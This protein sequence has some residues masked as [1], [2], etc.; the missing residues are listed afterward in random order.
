M[1]RTFIALA[2]AALTTASVW[3]VP[4]RRITKTIEQP[5]GT[6][7]EVTL[8]GDEW[9]HSY[10][11]SDNLAVWINDEGYAVYVTT[12]GP[13]TILAH[14][15]AD[16]S[17]DEQTAIAANSAS[18]N[19]AAVRAEAPKY[20]A[21]MAELREEALAR[22]E[23][24]GQDVSPYRVSSTT[25]ED[26][27][28]RVSLEQGASQVPHKGTAKVPIILVNFSNVSFKNSSTAN[29]TFT[30]F[31]MGEDN[32]SCHK[33]FSDASNGLYDPQFDI[34]GPFTVANNRKY[35]GGSS[36]NGNDE[37]PQYLVRDALQLADPTTDF[38]EY[39]NDGDGIVDVVIVLYA[40]V[41]QAS[42]GVAEAVWPCQW[43]LSSGGVGKYNTNDGVK[44]DKFA[45][46]NELNGANQS[47]I[48]GPGT[49]CHEFSHCLGLPDFYETTY[50]YGYMG[51]DVW[52]LMDYGC[53]N[54]DG[55]TP[56]GYTAYEKAFM[57]WITLLEGQPNTKYNLPVLNKEGE[58]N[59]DAVIL[60]NSKDK[61]EY[62]IFEN[63]DKQGWDKYMD[64][65]GMLITHVTYSSSA[66]SNNSVNNYSLQRM[67]IVP[68]DNKFDTY[69][70]SGD[71]W[72]KSYAYE[73]TNTSVP[74][75]TTNTGSFLNREVTEISR[76]SSTGNVTFWVDRAPVS[77]V[78]PPVIN[79][80]EYAP[81]LAEE[82]GAFT[83]KWG[84]TEIEGCDVSYILQVWEKTDGMTMP[85]VW[86]DFTKDT[87]V[88]WNQDGAVDKKKNYV[89]LGNTSGTTGVLTSPCTVAAEDGCI[90]VVAYAKR[91]GTDSGAEIKLSLV[92]ST[93]ATG[94]F[95]TV[96]LGNLKQY[97]KAVLKGE[98]GKVYSVRIENT[99][100]ARI[101]A[102]NV[103]AFEGD[104]SDFTD[105]EFQ[106]ALNAAYNAEAAPA[107]VEVSTSPAGR[108]TVKGIRETSY[109]VTGLEN[110]NGTYCYRV[111]AVP[112][113]DTIGL[114]SFWSNTM[115]VTLHE[116]NA[117]IV[118]VETSP[119]TSGFTVE[120]GNILATPGARLYTMSGLEVRATAAGRFSV[121]PGAYILITPGF[122]PSKVIVK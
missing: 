79:E 55:Y 76:D 23:A 66:W 83:A 48:D 91:F 54:D 58:Q 93:G 112:D 88:T 120:N 94:N 62:F 13:T 107:R 5:D 74:A 115:E 106:E 100:S 78:T 90:T 7:V 39:D 121:A 2:L 71:L 70:R 113:D 42:S 36:G 111:K 65:K 89:V 35:Y 119:A 85:T 63:R 53:Y 32:L 87:P 37:K 68:A 75:A 40:G 26:G 117:A 22:A 41:G 52:S 38:S 86:Q 114:E 14:N 15:P 51:M 43:S 20:Q 98:A 101:M 109:Q 80:E 18:M 102:Y 50:Y 3:A 57:G 8:Q 64:D 4:A 59:T 19:F 33:Y 10:V 122:R 9:F 12:S 60:I 95:T 47:K 99:G 105:E 24:A 34:I 108:I 6:T 27:I 1:K 82:D 92:E 17:A 67:T 11:T 96:S 44:C 28:P 25:G 116:H 81:E 69:T 30:E 56:C 31:F 72:P 104:Y 103:M 97:C 110:P 29:A 61:N 77:P 45:V 73:F 49:F 118:A 16:R 46:F 84:A 21:R